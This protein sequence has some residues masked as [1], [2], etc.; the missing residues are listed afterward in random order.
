[1]NPESLV[2]AI[3]AD[4]TSR[5]RAH[6][7]LLYGSQVD[8]SAS[9]DSDY[10]VAVF[11][12]VEAQYRDVRMFADQYLDVFIYP[13]RILKSPGPEHLLMRG[14]RIM[15]QQGNAADSF[16]QALETIFLQGP[17]S[18]SEDEIAVRKA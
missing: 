11:A 14:G 4:L 6:T 2:T 3:C 1:M 9:P 5:H 13:L 8:G 17:K 15:Y 7:V 18:L 16:L 12:D 10:D